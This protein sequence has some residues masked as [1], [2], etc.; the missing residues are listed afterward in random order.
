MHPFFPIAH[1]RRHFDLEPRL[2]SDRESDLEI[3]ATALR[4]H[5]AA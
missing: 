1:S 3:N 4:R 5:S 2:F